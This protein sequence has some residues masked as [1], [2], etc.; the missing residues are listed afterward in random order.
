MPAGLYRDRPKRVLAHG[1]Q[2]MAITIDDNLNF[3]TSRMPPA[4][5]CMGSLI[6][7][8]VVQGKVPGGTQ[9]QRMRQMHLLMQG[10]YGRQPP[11]GAPNRL[12]H[13]SVGV[14]KGKSNKH[15]KL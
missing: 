10:F 9:K 1:P 5:D 2:I 11:N 6:W 7:H 4:H 8:C 14:A 3:W 15:P 13:L 12:P